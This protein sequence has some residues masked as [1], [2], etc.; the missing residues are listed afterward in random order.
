MLAHGPQ[1]GQVEFQPDNK[2]QKHDAKF[3]Q[4]AHAFSFLRQ[5]QR[6]GPHCNP[7]R[8]I[9]QH[10]WQLK[11]AADHDA[12]NGGQQVNEGNFKSGHGHILA[13][14]VPLYKMPP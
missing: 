10:G 11:V 4:V 1:F 2:H 13:R 6:V 9:A 7:N 14:A 8:Q 5:C 12:Q 3:T